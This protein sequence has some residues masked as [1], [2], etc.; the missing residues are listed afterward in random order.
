MA[1]RR[2]HLK[3]VFALLVLPALAAPSVHAQATSSPAILQMFEAR[4]D[5]IEDRMADI[6][7]VGYGRMWVPPPNRASGT[8]SVGYDVFDRFSFGAA[9]DETRYGTDA[10]FRAM[11][12]D[13]HNAGVGI[14]PDLLWNHNGVGNRTDQNFVNLGGYPGFALTLPTDIN[15]DFHD[16]F[17][18]FTQ[19]EIL[20]QLAGL[21]DIAQE[22]HY[23]FF[24][25]PVDAGNPN[26]I[27]AGTLFNKADPNN[28]RFYPDQDLGGLTVFDQRSGQNV[29]LYSFNQQDPLQGDPVLEDSVGLLM[30]NVRWM[31]QEYDVD[32][33][34]LDAA[35]HFPREVLNAFDIASFRAKREPLLD[36]STNHVYSFIET[37]FDSA[38]FLQ[39]FIRRDIDDNNLGTVGGNRD[40][41]D[42]RLFNRLKDNLTP[43]VDGN[44][45]H[46]VRD[47]AMD[48]NDDGFIN[49]SQGVAFTQSHDEGGSFLGNVAHAYTLML[50]G[51]ALV[52]MNADAIPGE[53]FPQDGRDDALGGFYGDAI[54]KL[55]ELRN[56]HGRGDFHERWIDEAFGDTNG[57][58]QRSN[59]YAYERSNS[60]VVGLNNRNDTTALTRNGVQTSFAPGAILVELTGNA[61]L[62][63][64]PE[65]VAVNG[66][67]Q[68]NLTVPANG[69]HGRGYVV[70][71]VAPPEGSLQVSSTGV[72]E[73]VTP[74]SANY[75]TVRTTDI[76][77][78]STPTFT[79]TLNTTPVSAPNPSGPGVVRDQHADGDT[80]LLMIDGGRDL[81]GNGSVDNVTPGDVAY[82][83]EAFT[84]T[85]SPG[86]SWDGSQNVG[87]GSGVYQQVIDAT[88][89]S[90]GRHYLTARAFRHR[91]ASTGGDG[92]PAVFTDFKK[93]IYVDLLPPESELE[94]FEPFSSSPGNPNNRDLIVRSVDQTAEEVY[95]YL[96]LAANT[97]DQDILAMVDA[98]LGRASY[99]DRDRFVSGRFGVT[100]GNHVV[101]IVTV[102]PT[103]TTSIKRTTGVTTDTNIGLG[104]GDLNA[105]GGVNGADVVGPAGLENLL[106]SQN[107]L[108]NAAADVNGDGLVD[109][110]DLFGLQTEILSKAINP[111]VATQFEGVLLRR[112]NV[113]GDSR[114]NADDIAAVY[115][116]LGT[117]SWLLDID[118]NG[119][120]ELADAQRL[121]TDLARTTP[122]DFNLDGSVDALDYAVWREGQGV[123]PGAD[124]DFDGDSDADD[125]QIWLNAYGF[126]R[127]SLTLTPGAA[128]L[129]ATPAPTAA[130]LI[131]LLFARFVAA[132][133]TRKPSQRTR[134]PAPVECP[135][136]R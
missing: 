10:S 110:I 100:S 87:T 123:S 79:A 99:Y 89:L 129:H 82:G 105:D 59:Y 66:S 127:Q 63:G 20:G 118:G 124:A 16:P 121:V 126:Q 26:N 98:N 31:I 97:S 51:N 135:P 47:A 104:L 21:N 113:N 136:T 65:S 56:S 114:T 49:G 14:N 33:F 133:P 83:F 111:A 48:L 85:N 9:R 71:G 28:A 36:G 74:T 86:Y 42:F 29:T 43:S 15:G 11:I 41:L 101:T 77:V 88:Q 39:G 131:S 84:T 6:H 30:R 69:A 75:G 81:N 4:W 115:A 2:L 107:D 80:A 132:R 7:Q 60:A 54:T 24:R 119:V 50:P 35:R 93:T 5:L 106:Y 120:V 95:V 58:G 103:G 38:A 25:H 19:D 8:L 134:G 94:S 78:I 17:I 13:A 73:G 34:R 62:H 128:P 64:T 45:W 108:F 61:A 57:D 32:G 125:L 96:D 1:S 3:L 67:G 23:M 12:T 52:Y 40:S 92:G 27:P 130:S 46:G 72:L 122:G 91:N 55:V 53:S 90:E 102:E 117:D 76:H 44:N 70:Y 112:G 18:D 68:I 109:N 37:G 116:G 22:K